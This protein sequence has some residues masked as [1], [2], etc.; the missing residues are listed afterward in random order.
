MSTKLTL[1]LVLL[2]ACA[3][4]DMTSSPPP[5]DFGGG[6]GTDAFGA[7]PGD[8][9]R[10]RAL[11]AL[12]KDLIKPGSEL[13]IESRLGVPTF[14]WAKP[15][16]APASR[17]RWVAQGVTR[18]EVAAARAAVGTYA[19]LYGL[20]DADL[21]HAVVSQVDAKKNAATIVK[22]RSQIGGIEVFREELAVILDRNLDAVAISGYLSSI[23]TPPARAG[24]MD[25]TLAE[26]RAVALALA[27]QAKAPIDLALVQP[28]AQRDGY[29]HFTLA[30]AAGI[31][32]DEAV[33]VKRMY[34]R[35]PDGLEAA[36]YLEVAGYTGGPVEGEINVDGFD[37][38]YEAYAYLVSASTGQLLFK[39]NLIDHDVAYR[40]FADPV[41]KLPHDTPSGNAVHPK[42]N[43]VPDG[44]QHPFITP[45][46]VTLNSFPFSQNDPWLPPGATETVGNNVD[47]FVNLV[48]AGST[49][50]GY[51]PVGPAVDPP[52]GDYR[53]Q[54]T[55]ADQFLH[56]NDPATNQGLAEGRQGAI[57][58]LFYDINFF[59]DWYYDAG[60]DEVAGN[61]QTSNYGRGGLENDNIKGQAQDT[62][63]FSNANMQTPADGGRPRMRMYNFPS[64]ANHLE[65]TTAG[66]GKLR[67][68]ISQ[69]GPQNRA[70][71]TAEIVRATFSNTPTTCTVTNAAALDGKIALFDFDNTDGVGCAFGTRITRIA[72]TN[73]VAVVMAYTNT[74]TTLNTVANITGINVTH[75]KPIAVISWNSRV[76]IQAQLDVP[77]TVNAH[78]L[79]DNHFDGT[80]DNQIVAHEWM[81]Y[82]SNRLVGNAAGL[83][84]NHAAGMGEGWGDF[85]AM[86]LTVRPDDIANPTNATWNGAY[87]LATHALGGVPFSG[88]LNNNFYFGIRR[89]P[90]STDM[91]INP[92]TFKHIQN[93]VALPVGPPVGFGADGAQN[94]EVHNTGEV[95]AQMLW[96]CYAGL[97]R[98]TQGPT[99]RLTFQQAQDRMKRYVIGGLKA[100]PTFPTFTEARDG[101]LAVALATD[102]QDYIAC[103]VGFAK[104]GAGSKAVSPDRFS[105]NNVPVVEDFTVGPDL[106]F[107]GAT[108]DDSLG[109]CDNDGVVDHGEYGKLA[110]TVRNTGITTLA[111]T[112]ATVTTSSA[113]LWFPSG[114]TITFPA[115][116][117]G[118][119]QTAFVRVAL[120]PTS[121]GIAQA[122][123]AIAIDDPQLAGAVNAVS[124]F[125]IDTDDVPASSATDS[126]EAL[127]ASAWSLDHGTFA[128]IA[129]FE[130]QFVTPLDREWHV[131]DP[132]SGSDQRLLSPVFTVDGSG[133]FRVEFDHS[134]SFEFDGGGNYDGGVVEMSVNGGAFTDVGTGY[135]GTLV[136]YTGNVNPLQGRPAYVQTGTGHVAI[137]QAVAPGS[138]VQLR[139]REASDAGA[140]AAG[141]NIDNI[142]FAGVV[143]TPFATLVADPDSCTVV[144]SSADLAITKTNG[145]TSV[146][147]GMSTTY[148][149]TAS[150]AGPGNVIGATVNDTFPAD[151]ASCTWTCVGAGGG[152]CTASGAGNIAD[153]VTLP[154]GG[155]TT[156]TATC[157]VSTTSPASTL[158][159]TATVANPGPV[160]D[161]NPANNSAT[162]TDQLIHLPAHLFASKTVAGTFTQNG[163]VTYTVIMGNNGAGAQFDNSGDEFA[164]VLPAGLTLV[165]A[166]ATSGTAVSTLATNTVTWNGAVP[167]GGAV[168]ITIVATIIAGAG[169]TISNQGTFH[170]DG[171]GNGSNESTG[172]TDAFP[173]N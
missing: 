125:R 81:H 37:H 123:F 38:A 88:A 47:A 49:D 146:T 116:P 128:D 27:H 82:S 114:N 162:D 22:L 66:I 106:A 165:S 54:A 170:F 31:V 46:D 39:K 145:T 163:T 24:A 79:R 4:D 42:L 152:A 95:W 159:N 55:G 129:P 113:G 12:A 115:V 15:P 11:R 75:T 69:T 133:S 99:P 102:V 117:V 19:P 154:A 166:S 137:T 130:R 85:N 121:T 155:S 83:G 62:A 136:V 3:A 29:Q 58:Q 61:A 17:A 10:T 105:A 74:P 126:V 132:G 111:Q 43:L 140:G 87:A 168:T 122:D 164:D 77:V 96:E 60:F 142:A 53:A 149:I 45:S 78:L 98:D 94:A 32:L 21:V 36:Y 169:T 167:A 7:R 97:L 71:L 35:L 9:A 150:N 67:I 160:T 33:R 158:A 18:P 65:V 144:P 16:L 72:A 171:D 101:V 118:G 151:L 156:Y 141:W 148:T 127:G 120:P 8:A 48:N 134:W 92:L 41:T 89:Y 143:E 44:A 110:V 6:K 100:T 30:P 153:S 173:C 107:E 26:N 131:D 23:G 139:F 135:N 59:H 68:G 34:Y 112:T 14:L 51:G 172:V 108:F 50:N 57:Q 124:S 13:Q 93:G 52:T 84:T 138:T 73:A 1:S 56:T 104:R 119:T 76:A 2:A 161:P 5:A 147:A 109:S 64:P 157:T 28:V 63:T 80:V 91:A 103:R 90:Y 70:D 86:M 25:F 20:T 40:V